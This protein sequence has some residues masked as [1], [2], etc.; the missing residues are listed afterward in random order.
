MSVPLL[1]LPV[2]RWYCPNCDQTDVTRE[3][4]PHSRMHTCPGLRGLTAP[5]IA[6]GTRAKVERRDPEDYVGTTLPHLDDDGRPASA[7]VTTRDDGQDTAVLAP[8]ISIRAGV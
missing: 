2:H 7:V 5:F 6:E 4:R 3:L 8:T 1:E